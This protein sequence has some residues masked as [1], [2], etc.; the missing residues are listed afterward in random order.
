MEPLE[1]DERIGQIVRYLTDGLSAEE[2]NNLKNWIEA[3]EGNKALYLQ[4]KNIWEIVSQ[5]NQAKNLSTDKAL[6]LVM[7]R[8]S[9][10]KEK[11]SLLYYWQRVAAVLL[12]PVLI[13]SFIWIRSLSGYYSS[14]ITYNEVT[15]PFGTRTAIKLADGSQVWLNSGSSLRYPD[16]FLKK[17]RTVF[18]SGEA[19]FE[20]QSDKSHPFVVQTSSIAIKA[21]GTKFNVSSYKNEASVQ[22]ALVEGKVSVMENKTELAILK[23]SQHLNFD[24]LSQS[25]T[26]SDETNMDKYV[27]W[28]EGK[29][30]FRNEPLSFV[31][32]RIGQYYNVDIEIIGKELQDYRYR[33]TFEEETIDEI[34]KLLR[35]SSP[36]NYKEI[37]REPLS[38]GSFPKRKIV[39]FSAN[40][41]FSGL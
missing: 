6:E 33:A 2:I 23:P 34:L 26:V 14:N 4:V 41:N 31:V 17:Q 19:F 35:M 9:P 11:H 32:K 13:G 25:I 29:F 24:T 40:K 15:A 10:K 16:K 20:V 28:K 36:I 21:T 38:D 8:L 7:N 27:A 30:V 12:I 37:K 5:A 22:V 39:I 1:I 3:S 18:L